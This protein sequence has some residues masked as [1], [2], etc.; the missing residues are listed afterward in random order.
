MYCQLEASESIVIACCKQN[1]TTEKKSQKLLSKVLKN[2]YG[3]KWA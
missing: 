2:E 1:G 3:K